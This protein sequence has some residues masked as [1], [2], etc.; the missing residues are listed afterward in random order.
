MMSPQVGHFFAFR[1]LMKYHRMPKTLRLA[2][3]MRSKVKTVFNRKKMCN[4]TSPVELYGFGA[5]GDVRCPNADGVLLH[6]WLEWNRLLRY[7][8][9][10]YA[11]ICCVFFLNNNKIIPCQSFSFV[12]VSLD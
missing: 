9:I 1:S 12:P 4:N 6:I 3:F 2:H 5:L 8:M 10:R 7:F 11:I